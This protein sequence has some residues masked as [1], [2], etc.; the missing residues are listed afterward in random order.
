MSGPVYG[1]LEKLALHDHACLFYRGAEELHSAL[2]PYLRIGLSRGEKC[3]LVCGKAAGMEILAGLRRKGVDIGSALARGAALVTQGPATHARKWEFDPDAL[4]AFFRSSARLAGSEKFA[5]LRLCVDMAFA[6]G[7]NAPRERRVEY[8]TKLHAF[9]ADQKSLC[10]CLFGMDDFPA[11]TLLDALR[12]HPHVLYGGTEVENFYF[13]PPTGDFAKVEEALLLRM[14]LDHLLD[15]QGQMTRVRRQ[16]NRLTRFRD[17][18]ASLLSH[19]AVPDLLNR[20]AEGVVSL[21][22]RM[23]WIGMAKADGTVEPVACS[24]DKEAYL[25]AIVVRWDDTPLGKG[26]VGTAIRTG[27]PDIVR[28]V[29]RSPRFAPWREKAIAR[30]YRSVAAIPIREEKRIGGALAVYASTPDAFDREA[31][32]EL[33][34][35]VLQASL[36]LQ[37][38]RDYRRLSLSEERLRTLFEQIPAACF[39]YD[40][41]GNIRHWNLHCRRLFGYPPEEAVGK[42][43]FRL[44]VRPEDEKQTRE[45]V[46]RVF[47]GESIFNLQW[48]NRVPSGE[49]AWILSNTYPFRGKGA[50]VELGISVNVDITRQVEDRRALAKSEARF[51]AVVENANA[52]AVEIDPEGRILLFNRAAE[53]ITGVPAAEALGREYLDFIAE[54]EREQVARTFREVLSG[55]E[56]EGFL[57]TIVTREG[58]KRILAWNATAIR[59]EDGSA[60]CVVGLGVDM[61]ERLQA[62]Q[63]KEELRRNLVQAQKMEAIG[64]VAGGIAHEFNNLLG[65]IIG[66]ASLLE[67][68]MEADDP[69]SGAIRKIHRAADRASDLTLKLIGFARRGKYQVRP[70]SFN[71]LVVQTVPLLEK[72]LDRS[73]EVRTELDPSIESIEGDEGQLQH[74]LLDLCF[75]A[76]DAMPRGGTLTVRTGN[77]RIEAGEVRQ[78]HMRKPGDYVFLEVKDTGEG[79]TA[80]VQQRIFEPFFTTRR[81]QGHTGMGLPSIYGIVK[82]H[83]GGIHVESTPGVGSLFR[84]YLPGAPMKEIP[85][86]PPPGEAYPK[87]TETILVV[88]DEPEIREMGSEL[89]GALGYR[90]ITAEDGEA[91]CRIFRERAGEIGLVLLDIIMPKMGGKETFR[92]LRKMS[93]GLPVLLSSGYSV[94][95]LAREILGEGANGF[96]QKPYGFQELARTIRR[97]LDAGGPK[98]PVQTGTG[99]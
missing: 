34:A 42:S 90:T 78:Y 73:I 57:T 93:P 11:G 45:I 18:A 29:S 97:I 58:T 40:R 14:R 95:D 47:S 49:S 15:R 80:E 3:L 28:D 24:G 44:I 17:I 23:C 89:L 7:K 59:N 67:S 76:R 60:R 16:A 77:A 96:I 38:A 33:S 48:K 9:L 5:G 71:D 55:K 36:A 64:A 82:N 56:E 1:S 41:E 91:A 26:P 43:I 86:S 63:E 83:N 98:S 62:E 50:A 52:V 39:T 69:H 4:I 51:R 75:N 27:K 2:V 32:E 19:V 84:I 85:A 65:A 22:Y 30:G 81:E 72:A 12:A 6:F 8:Q 10:L 99:A 94:E 21:G 35:F 79:M 20:I 46:D 31:I 68:R 74:C 92:A 54:P 66:Y 88:D 61:T 25:Q 87:G 53:R 13:I 70:L 37:S